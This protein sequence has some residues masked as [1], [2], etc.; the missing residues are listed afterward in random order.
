[1]CVRVRVCVHVRMCTR[2]R[3]CACEYSHIFVFSDL[4]MNANKS[5]VVPA[6]VTTTM[7]IGCFV[8]NSFSFESVCAGIL[9]VRVAG[10]ECGFGCIQR[11]IWRLLRWHGVNG[12]AAGEGDGV[13]AST[14]DAGDDMGF[15][16]PLVLV[17]VFFFFFPACLLALP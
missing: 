14:A 4:S 12:P 8:T 5:S 3:L 9:W 17:L 6:L 10:R 1:M 16:L 15:G 13:V 2:A 11:W 7:D